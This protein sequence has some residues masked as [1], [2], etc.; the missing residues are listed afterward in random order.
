MLRSELYDYSNAYIVVKERISIRGNN[1]ANWV[2]KNH[3]FQKLNI[4]W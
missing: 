2:N 1:N 3:A 4:N